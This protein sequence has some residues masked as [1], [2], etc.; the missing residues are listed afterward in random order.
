MSIANERSG[1]GKG[2][3]YDPYT[4]EREVQKAIVNWLSSWDFIVAWLE[5]TGEPKEDDRTKTAQDYL[6]V[7][8]RVNSGQAFDRTGKYRI[9]L[10]SAGT[11]DLMVF[12]PGGVMMFVEVKF[13]KRGRVSDVQR[14]LHNRLR[15]LGY[16][17]VVAWGLTEVE[18]AVR[19]AGLAWAN[20]NGISPQ[21]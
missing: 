12:L 7:V 20:A 5:T 21:K 9:S 16:L 1:N 18:T 14:D 6:P 11:P 17:V 19:A 13:G 3:T 8:I 4:S 15:Q 10:A 2:A